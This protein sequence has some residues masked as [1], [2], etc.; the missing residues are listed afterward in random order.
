[1]R[2]CF[3]IVFFAI[4]R[5]KLCKL[6]TSSTRISIVISINSIHII[7]I[8]KYCNVHLIQSTSRL[9]ASLK[10]KISKMFFVAKALVIETNFVLAREMMS[11]RI[12]YNFFASMIKRSTNMYW[13]S[14]I[15]TSFMIERFKHMF[16]T[17]EFFVYIDVILANNRRFLVKFK[18][19]TKRRSTRFIRSW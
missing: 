3:D 15:E 4:I 7:Y 17:K 18:S 6:M 2:R 11:M 5:H 9:I 8:Y 12:I 13:L 10:R 19:Y 16:V 14:R 1:M